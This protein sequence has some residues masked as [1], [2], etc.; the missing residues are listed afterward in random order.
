MGKQKVSEN[1]RAVVT[2]AGSGIGKAFAIELSMRG[3]DIVV[4]DVDLKLAQVTVDEIHNLGN[5]ATGI[6]CDVTKLEDVESLAQEAELWFGQ[7]PNFV[8]NNAGVGLG[9]SLLEDI[10]IDDWD[11]IMN[12]NLWGVI[13]GCHVFVP[14][15][16]LQAGGVILN[17]ASA[18]SFGGAPMMG[19]YNTT[20]AAVLALTETL[21]AELAGSGVRAAV[22]CPTL[23]KTNIIKN[24]KMNSSGTVKAQKL[25]DRRGMTPNKAAKIA[26]DRIDKG[27]IHILPQLDARLMWAIK[28]MAPKLFIRA[29]GFSTKYLPSDKETVD[30]N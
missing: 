29:M 28:R 12:I 1:T 13:H 10:S 19:A 25:M 26:L 14:C 17:V 6:K 15:L 21:S 24:A 22:M 9:G 2:G 27:A 4:S 16:R 23:I 5:R 8:I 11:W 7:P 20:K 18:A 30:A 3:G